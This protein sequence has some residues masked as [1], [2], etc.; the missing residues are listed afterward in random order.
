MRI[1]DIFE[2]ERF[3]WNARGYGRFFAGCEGL[4]LWDGCGKG[5]YLGK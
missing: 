2:K 1:N 3:F 4:G 5:E